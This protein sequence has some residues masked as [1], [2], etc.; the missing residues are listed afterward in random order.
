MKALTTQL[1]QITNKNK[2]DEIALAKL[3]I[4]KLFYFYGITFVNL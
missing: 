3:I 4:K 2:H 1:R